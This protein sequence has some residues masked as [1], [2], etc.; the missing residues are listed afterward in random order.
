MLGD[1]AVERSDTKSSFYENIFRK[2]GKYFIFDECIPIVIVVIVQLAK[3]EVDMMYT[4]MTVAKY[5]IFQMYENGAY[6][7]E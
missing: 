5:I 3:P 7:G 1:Y 4:A 6:P 2:A